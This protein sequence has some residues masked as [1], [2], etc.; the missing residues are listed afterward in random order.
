MEQSENKVP[1]IFVFATEGLFPLFLSGEQAARVLSL[2]R[3]TLMKLLERG[4]IAGEK[5]A[6][7]GVWRISTASLCEY[8]DLGWK[9]VVA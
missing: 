7:T 9:T 6:D 3:P 4:D 2:S 5:N 1:K 8:L